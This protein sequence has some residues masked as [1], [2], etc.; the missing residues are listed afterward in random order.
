MLLIKTVSHLEVDS[1]MK[2]MCEVSCL[3]K[4]AKKYTVLSKTPPTPKK[5]KQERRPKLIVN[6]SL[7]SHNKST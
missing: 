7:L 4:I 6:Y 2:Y 5:R 3:T 1:F